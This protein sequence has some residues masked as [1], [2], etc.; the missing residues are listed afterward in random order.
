M[1]SKTCFTCA[2]AVVM[3]SF[4]CEIS[5]LNNASSVAYPGEIVAIGCCVL[6]EVLVV[7][8]GVLELVLSRGGYS[9]DWS[10]S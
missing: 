8:A 5:F 2:T 7:V 4:N 9:V 3:I 6:V 1:E 10:E